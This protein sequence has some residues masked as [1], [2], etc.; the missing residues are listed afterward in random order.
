M[1][2][3]SPRVAFSG[4]VFMLRNSPGPV[5]PRIGPVLKIG[6]AGDFIERLAKKTSTNAL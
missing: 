6:I 4:I 1:T 2:R 5:G 3:N